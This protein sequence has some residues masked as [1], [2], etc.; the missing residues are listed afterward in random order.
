MNASAARSAFGTPGNGQPMGVKV[1]LDY[2]HTLPTGQTAEPLRCQPNPQVR[3]A[4]PL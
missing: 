4:A 2:G 1:V 3:R